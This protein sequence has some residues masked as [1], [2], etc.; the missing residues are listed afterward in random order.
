MKRLL[1]C[2]G[3]VL[4]GVLGSGTLA[5]AGGRAPMVTPTEATFVVGPNDPAGTTWTLNLWFRA[6]SSARIRERQEH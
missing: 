4:V 3:A 2:T 6:T 1:L 5:F